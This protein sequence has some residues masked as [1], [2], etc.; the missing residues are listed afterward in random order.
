LTLSPQAFA[1]IHLAYLNPHRSQHYLRL[2][3]RHQTIA[4]KEFRGILQN[5]INPEEADALFG[6]AAVISTSAMARACEEAESAEIPNT[7]SMESVAE[8]FILTRG[9][10]DV[11]HATSGHVHNGPMVALFETQRLPPDVPPTLPA[12]VEQ[13]FVAIGTMLRSWGLDHEALEYCEAALSGLREIY[14]VLAYLGTQEIIEAGAVW[15]WPV[16]APPGFIR[17]VRAGCQ[18]ACVIVAYFAAATSA[19]RHT[20]YVERWGGY[21]INGV[22][23]VLDESMQHWVTWPRQQWEVRMSS[24]GLELPARSCEPVPLVGSHDMDIR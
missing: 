22:E 9:I 18:P 8:R 2:C 1:A 15:R 10:S 7:V 5:E 11:I 23:L 12:D 16:E 24:L 3:D 17:L 21:V 6:L 13:H 20:W 4:L 19:V 14:A